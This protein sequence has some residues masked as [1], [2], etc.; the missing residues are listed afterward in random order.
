MFP[1]RLKKY[2]EHLTNLL[3]VKRKK[4]E[5]RYHTRMRNIQSS[6]GSQP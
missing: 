4:L 5:L 1:E 6:T 2:M 3:G